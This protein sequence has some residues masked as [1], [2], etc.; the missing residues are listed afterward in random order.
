MI[1]LLNSPV[2]PMHSDGLN[3]YL[4]LQVESCMVNMTQVY[5][6][7]RGQVYAV[8]GIGAIYY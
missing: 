5:A 7:R 2:F 3:S 6:R 4:T 8:Y 1:A